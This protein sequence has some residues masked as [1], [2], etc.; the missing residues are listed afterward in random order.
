MLAFGDTD[1]NGLS[2]DFLN[3]LN[4]FVNMFKDIFNKYFCFG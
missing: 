1:F 2:L 4:T 3:R